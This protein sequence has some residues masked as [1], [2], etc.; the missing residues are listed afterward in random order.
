MVDDGR[1]NPDVLVKALQA[2]Q[3]RQRR[4]RLHIFFGY[5]P[6]VGKTYAMLRAGRAAKDD[7]RDVVVGCVETHGRQETEALLQALPPPLPRTT[8]AHKGT[9]LAEFDLD[10]AL[11]RKPELLL[12][13]ELAHT[14]APGSRHAKRWQDVLELLDAGIDVWTT[15]N[16][17]HVESLNDAVAQVTHIVVKETVPDEVLDRADEFVLVDLSPDALLERLQEGK[18]YMPAVAERALAHF[19]KRGNLLALRELALRRTA[20]RVDAEVRAFR[21]EHDIRAVWPA[22]TRILAC[23]G[24]GHSTPRVLRAARRM[25]DG[26]D[27]SWMAV[28]VDSPLLPQTAAERRRLEKHL[29]MAERLGAEVVRLSGPK[30]SEVLL[31]HAR[32][33][34]V[35]LIVVGQTRHRGWRA[36]RD[37]PSGSIVDQLL[38]DNEGIDVRVV[39]RRSTEAAAEV[40]ERTPSP[41]RWSITTSQALGSVA[42]VG[43]ATGLSFALRALGP[44]DVVMIYLAVIMVVAARFGAVASLIASALSVAAFDFFFV[45]PTFTFAVADFRFAITFAMMFVVGLLIS[46]LMGRLRQEREDAQRRE[47]RTRSQLALT[48]SL[49]DADDTASVAA[50]LARATTD[51]VQRKATVV[52]AP[53]VAADPAFASLDDKARSLVRW[54]LANGRPAGRGS[55]TLPSSSWLCLPLALDER[56]LGVL[57]IEALDLREERVLLSGRHSKGSPGEAPAPPTEPR[58][59][60]DGEQKEL[61]DA[62]ARQTGIAL[63]RLSLVE[64]ARRAA[65]QARTE[66]MRSTLLSAVSHDLRTPLATIT[67]AATMLLDTDDRLPADERLAMLK[68]IAEEGFHLEQLV[69]SLLDM[70]RLETGALTVKRDWVPVDEIVGSA[71]ARVEDLLGR[72]VVTTNLPADLPLV[73]GDPVLL[74]QVLVN[75]LENVA[76]HTPLR[77][78]VDINAR[79]ADDV[80]GAAPSIEISVAD[81]GPGLPVVDKGVDIFGKF[82]RGPGAKPGGAGLGLAIVSGLV[83]AHGGSVSAHNRDGG[84]AVFVVR[85]PV[86]PVPITRDTEASEDPPP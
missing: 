4:A 64:E 83:M 5:A 7:G 12:V 24:P 75:L 74:Q 33:E 11:K 9:A 50:V 6:G 51:A 52:L 26:A 46:V 42:L 21:S 45:Q 38:R 70:T 57:L 30:I 79:V 40:D 62:F 53:E 82:V 28:A 66:E 2:E 69:S 76:R 27:A 56:V 15:L 8:V 16:V 81:R 43:V 20:E 35:T 13:D 3:Q 17:Q 29:E 36:L 47:R 80:E 73:H 59:V 54:V 78:P 72:R 23:V 32:R 1:P 18:V 67:G 39:A 55:D 31:E 41:A 61:I 19:F 63:H 84:G 14:N 10:A 86:V 60:L 71:L 58:S 25:A 48:R 68:V 77:T 85:L 44:I 34:N 65:V 49:V 37:L 22:A